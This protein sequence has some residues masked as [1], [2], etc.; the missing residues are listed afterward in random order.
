MMSSG[1]FRRIISGDRSWRC[2]II[3]GLLFSL[4]IASPVSAQ[5]SGDLLRLFQTFDRMAPQHQAPRHRVP[6]RPSREDVY[7]AQRILNAIGYNAGPED[8]AMGPRTHSALIA[9]QRE[10]GLPPSGQPDPRTM[11]ALEQALR[12]RAASRPAPAPVSQAP[13]PATEFVGYYEA[14][15]RTASAI[16]G[17]I[18]VAP[19]TITFGNGAAIGL[20]PVH[21]RGT[22][23][24][25]PPADPPLLSGQTLCGDA[26]PRVVV[27]SQNN[28]GFIGL[29]VYADSQ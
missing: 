28:P 14:A 12:S 20:R 2:G 25:D 5:S 15:S 11:A 9:F 29:S 4:P 13:A 18:T 1:W 26:P 17:D 22:F 21:R 27:L 3:A 16:T 10:S 24:V 8:G 7:R 6:A 23:A 19:E